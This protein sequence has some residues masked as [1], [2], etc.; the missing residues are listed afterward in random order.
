M[1][2]GLPRE[3]LDLIVDERLRTRVTSL[4]KPSPPTHKTTRPSPSNRMNSRPPQLIKTNASI[5]YWRRVPFVRKKRRHDRAPQRL[6]AAAL[7]VLKAAR[8]SPYT[9]A[10]GRV[11]RRRGTR[12]RRARF[13]SG[14]RM[15]ER[16]SLLRYRG[17]M[18]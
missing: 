17:F 10:P 4:V 14:A 16:N 15:L 13:T 7:V 3:E 18:R 8:R 5:L 1:L 11:P 9:A 12:A 6:E 2:D